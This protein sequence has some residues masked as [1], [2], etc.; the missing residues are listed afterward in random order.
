MALVTVQRINLNFH[1]IG[2][3]NIH[4]AGQPAKF[5]DLLSS[6]EKYKYYS[7]LLLGYSL[8]SIYIRGKSLLDAEHYARCFGIEAQALWRLV[9]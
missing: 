6:L 3:D 9:V 4:Q 5:Q 7:A 8:E 1:N 2:Y